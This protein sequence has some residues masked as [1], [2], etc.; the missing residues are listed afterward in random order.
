VIALSRGLFVM[1]VRGTPGTY[2]VR[3]TTK[4]AARELG[5]TTTTYV[6]RLIR[7][8]TLRAVKRGPAWDVDA[9]SVAVYKARVSLKRSSRSNASAQ[10]ERRK[11]EGRALYGVTA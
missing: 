10:R 3:M 4:D 2:T 5:Y 11:A 7:A 6:E 9:D 1:P 8:G